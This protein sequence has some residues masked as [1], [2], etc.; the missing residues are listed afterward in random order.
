MLLHFSNILP[1]LTTVLDVWYSII[2]LVPG[3]GETLL[4]AENIYTELFQLL[5]CSVH[6]E[7]V[8]E[9]ENNMIL[10]QFYK[11]VKKHTLPVHSFTRWFIII[12]VS[13]SF[14]YTLRN[15]IVS[16]PNRL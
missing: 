10:Y 16:K 6:D 7:I 13:R 14:S 5:Q 4:E 15:T 3:W 2:L 1:G 12:I 8:Q 9:A 11:N